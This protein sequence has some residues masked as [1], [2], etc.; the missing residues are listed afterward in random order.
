MSVEKPFNGF[1]EESVRFL[2]SLR[3]NNTKEWF[4]AHKQEYDIFIKEPARAFVIEMGKRLRSLR[5]RLIADPR[6]NR[7]LFRI[8]RDTRFSPDKSPYK[9]NVAIYLWEGEGGKFDCPGFYFDLN[10]PNFLLGVGIYIF[11]RHLLG[12]YRKAVVDPEFG[13][14]LSDIIKG[15]PQSNNSYIGGRHYKRFPAGFD[16]EHPNADLLLHNGL[17]IGLEV[18]IFSEVYSDE[19]ADYCYREVKPLVPL[20]EWLVDLTSRS[21][22][23]GKGVF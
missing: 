8:N 2:T 10:P 19:L 3:K 15:L 4:Q 18:P 22:D 16:T 6:I 21:W 7:S 9:T 23:Q 20:H 17:Y 13:M 5:P 14:E 11:A 1:C 12:P